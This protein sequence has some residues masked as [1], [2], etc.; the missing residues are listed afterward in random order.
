MIEGVIQD[1]LGIIQKPK[2]SDVPCM[3]YPSNQFLCWDFFAAFYSNEGG[4]NL[5]TM[6][7]QKGVSSEYSII[8]DPEC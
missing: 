5:D 7:I 3:L 6:V 4:S 8:L 1:R 2:P